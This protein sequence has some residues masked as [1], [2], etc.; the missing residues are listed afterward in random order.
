MKTII[1]LLTLLVSLSGSIANSQTVSKNE[2]EFP[3]ELKTM[4]YYQFIEKLNLAP[5]DFTEYGYFFIN[6]TLA[7][8]NETGKVCVNGTAIF[9][10]T[11]KANNT[12]GEF[13]VYYFSVFKA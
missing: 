10:S 13:E 6:G 9:N 1:F 4:W 12:T 5:Q 3:E 8:A 11:R 7:S 2:K